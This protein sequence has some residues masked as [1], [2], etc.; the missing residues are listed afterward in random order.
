MAS[1]SLSWL[2]SHL[3]NLYG[4]TYKWPLTRSLSRLH[5]ELP[6]LGEELETYYGEFFCWFFY[7][8]SLPYL[9]SLFLWHMQ[10]V[11]L[12]LLSTKTT[13]CFWKMSWSKI[14]ISSLKHP[15][16][17]PMAA[18]CLLLGPQQAETVLDTCMAGSSLNFDVLFRHSS[19]SFTE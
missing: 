1:R 19:L 11:L 12:P 2:V 15:W 4:S 6:L 3:G 8:H 14:Q 5:I 18:V 9:Y 13:L 7:P 17:F 16:K 10:A